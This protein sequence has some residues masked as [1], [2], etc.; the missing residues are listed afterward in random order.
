MK[1]ITYLM[2][3]LPFM[4]YIIENPP[5]NCEMKKSLIYK[6][7]QIFEHREHLI[8]KGGFGEVFG[9][10][11]RAIKVVNISNEIQ[12]E[13]L[14]KE[15]EIMVS[16]KMF[17]NL[18]GM[19]KNC[20]YY[21]NPNHSENPAKFYL[22]MSKKPYSLM[23]L[24]KKNDFLLKK[25]P[26]WK[27]DIMIRMARAVEAFLYTGKVHRDIKLS[28]FLMENE[29]F[30]ILADFGLSGALNE[31]TTSV[32]GTTNFI[33]PEMFTSERHQVKEYSERSDVYSLG[34]SFLILINEGNML[35]KNFSQ[36][37]DFIKYLNSFENLT[38]DY[39]NFFGEIILDM[40]NPD[41]NSRPNISKIV[42]KLEKI[43]EKIIN[44]K[45]NTTKILFTLKLSISL[46]IKHFSYQEYFER[47]IQEFLTNHK[48]IYLYQM[49]M[50]EDVFI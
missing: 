32:L 3:I 31:L 40:I 5:L 22:I 33:P 41:A 36:K 11:N 26:L 43:K 16:N 2:I 39:S 21:K 9:W 13:N 20:C 29:Y 30:P 50:N 8:G 7:S 14:R 46:K 18:M 10:R 12:Y 44:T 27:V 34:V 37:M 15:I 6:M 49:V 1:L 48:Y 47:S 24:I 17:P 4:G 23:D 35:T 45:N 38:P 25:D 42:S 28:N 19:C